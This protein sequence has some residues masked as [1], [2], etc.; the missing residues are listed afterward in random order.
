VERDP[1]VLS[2][3]DGTTRVW[4][5]CDD[6][7]ACKQ[8]IICPGHCPS[9]LAD[10]EEDLELAAK[11][12]QTWWGRHVLGEEV[13]IT[14]EMACNE[15]DAGPASHTTGSSTDHPGQTAGALRCS[16]CGRR[17]V[18][19]RNAPSRV[20]Q[21]MFSS[22][23]MYCGEALVEEPEDSVGSPPDSAGESQKLRCLACGYVMLVTDPDDAPSRCQRCHDPMVQYIDDDAQ[24][25]TI[26]DSGGSTQVTVTAGAE[27][28]PST[29]GAPVLQCFE[30]GKQQDLPAG[31]PTDHRGL[32]CSFCDSTLTA[33]ILFDQAPQCRQA[34]EIGR[35][36]ERLYGE[37]QYEEAA[38][39]FGEALAL[40]PQ[41]P[42]LLL[43]MGNALGMVGWGER[44]EAKLRES[45][46]YLREAH[47]LYPAY[48]RAL[49]NLQITEA[50]LAELLR[51][52]ELVC[53]IC[54]RAVELADLSGN[55][56]CR[57]CNRSLEEQTA[58]AFFGGKVPAAVQAAWDEKWAA[59]II[60]ETR[61]AGGHP[62]RRRSWARM[63][64][65]A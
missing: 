29:E 49:R 40:S 20:S 6:G 8:V 50:K 59:S 28:Q 45:L 22:R 25:I 60:P 41:D 26:G 37:E 51:E 63:T 16:A 42:V 5:G 65:R 19:S 35:E 3:L 12:A 30:C 17:P 15:G 54:E 61:G 13:Y 23:C 14:R 56:V 2:V 11:A 62:Q 64:P 48:E 46:D 24:I 55:L 57:D 39:T 33:V 7:K 10:G 21:R 36:G 34:K 43:D 58:A 9:F 52:R 31:E 44:N 53:A 18:T 47:E 38:S 4:P 1:G 32:A 27:F